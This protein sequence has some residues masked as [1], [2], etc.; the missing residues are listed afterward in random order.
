MIITQTPLR[1]SIAGGG[2]DLPGYYRQHGGYVVS[3]AIDKYLYVIVKARYDDLIYVD[4]SRKEI[5]ASIDEIQH[6][7]VREACRIT[8]MTNGF[9]VAMMADIPSE[10]SGLGSS[11]SLTV[12]LLNAFYQYRGE[13]VGP[14]RLAQE[15]CRIEI[16]ILGKPIGR[17][18][19]YI[20]AYGGLCAFEFRND[21]SVVMERIDI[22]PSGKR[23]LGSNILLFFTNIVRQASSIL[24]DQRE[25]IGDTIAFHDQIKGLAHE[26]RGALYSGNYDAVGDVLHRNWELK[27]Q[28]A[29][30]V[31]TGE[32]DEMYQAALCG[33]AMGGKIAGAGG[34]GFLMVYC[35]RPDQD[36][37]R[38]AL[39]TYREMPFL[40]EPHGSKVVFNQERYNWK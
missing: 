18:D 8:G 33:G 2:T 28:L 31:S 38:E 24:S 10:G 23:R 34:G 9:E 26:V 5:V 13:Q 15:A 1:I 39:S 40:L 25:K 22:Q 14:E 12:G 27:K 35:R 37:L 21:D 30:G 19:Q 11:S 36:N 29:N 4:Y 3:T 16:D 6:E 32:I 17:Q 7:L 20:A